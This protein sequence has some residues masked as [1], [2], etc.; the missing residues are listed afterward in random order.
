MIKNNT[1][2]GHALRIVVGIIL[3]VLIA[4]AVQAI[5]QPSVNVTII[6]SPVIMSGG[7]LPTTGP[8]G[9]LGDFRFTNLAPGAVSTANL[10]AFDTVVLNVASSQMACNVNILTAQQKADL[11]TFIGTGKKMIIYDSECSPQN[12]N[13]LPFPFTTANPGQMGA[14]GTL[15]I[16][17]ENTL[18]SNDPTSLYFINANYLSTSTDAVG[19]MNVMTTYDPYWYIDMSGTNI[20]SVTGPVHTYA[21]YPAGTDK[22]LFIYN[23]LDMDNM[24]SGTNSLRK[25]WLQELQQKF[26]PSDLPGSVSVVGITL[27]P[28]TAKNTVGQSHTVTAKL[29]DK[30]GNPQPGQVVTFNLI[31]GP[32]NGLNGQNTTDSN[33][34]ASFTYAGNSVGIDEIKACFTKVGQTICSQVVTKEWITITNNVPNKPSELSQNNSDG[35][36]IEEGDTILERTVVIK[37]IVSDPDGDKV[38]LQVEL[39]RTDEYG[40]NFDD[41]QGGLKNSSLVPSGSEVS[42]TVNGLINGNYHWRAR[43]I[44]ENDKSSDWV[45]FGTIP[46]DFTIDSDTDGDGLFDSW[47]TKGIDVNHDGQID[48]DLP[49][50]GANPNRKDIFVEVDYM[51]GHIFNEK[52]KNNVIR[53]FDHAPV[54]NPNGERD[55]INLHV[56]I[57]DSISEIN[58]L[59]LDRGPNGEW[60]DFDKIKKDY[61]GTVTERTN[62]NN[63]KAKKKAFRYALFINKFSTGGKTQGN[64]G[65][66]ELAGN[67]LIVSLGSDG[68]IE[69]QAGTFMHELGHTLNLTHD[70]WQND[71]GDPNGPEANCKPNYL[72]VMS[73]SRQFG[74]NGKI[75]SFLDY[76]REEL[77][78]LNENDLNEHLGVQDG[79]D[80][81]AYWY[82]LNILGHGLILQGIAYAPANGPI[83]WNRKD[84][85]QKSVSSDTNYN[86]FSDFVNNKDFCGV[87]G[88]QILKGYDDW[89]HLQYNFRDSN[90]LADGAH[91]DVITNELTSEDVKIL[92]EM[93]NTYNI[94]FLPPL[95]LT[96]PYKLKYGTTLPIKFTVNYAGKFVTDNSVNVTITDTKDN[97]IAIFSIGTGT[98]NVRINASEGQYIVNFQTKKYP[99]KVGENYIIYVTFNKGSILKGFESKNFNLVK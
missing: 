70:G 40:G 62:L 42:I 69:S 82:E 29:T 56:Q 85:I 80:V 96:D 53:S 46:V 47:E 84:G 12:Y 52:A 27:E 24:G 5:P 63:I 67:D 86:W 33:G 37:G 35:T 25:I 49:S 61:F 8:V 65:I 81:T 1:Y 54:T 88:I 77:P 94:T 39:R 41:S 14:Q 95:I 93:S 51:N 13:W 79:D 36:Q 98:D 59:N 87:R 75:P 11:V 18:S 30:L 15:T 74:G 31:S 73:Y 10:S 34:N 16:V 97:L 6:G 43:T 19:D 92:N 90:G 26:H 2:M 64:S 78:P 76:S 44:D 66:A 7:T 38:K 50:L 45:E 21:M 23:G 22:G 3:I 17:E 4:G 71:Y 32:N 89:K 72:S 58:P 55:G 20:L 57:D 48:L 83:D 28:G 9:E 60:N 68:T 99:L 91:P